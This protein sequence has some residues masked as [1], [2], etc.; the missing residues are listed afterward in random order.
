MAD[1]KKKYE[2]PIWQ[3]MNLTVEEAMAYSGI[4]KTK[5]YQMTDK[6]DCSFVL[7]IGSRRLLKRTK[8]EEYIEKSYSI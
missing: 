7:W 5:I 3:K 4:G 8:F 1:S 2:I 6:E